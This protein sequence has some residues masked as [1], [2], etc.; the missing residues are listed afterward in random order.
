MALY[1]AGYLERARA[2]FF[3]QRR[4]ISAVSP[5]PLNTPN[6]TRAQ[7]IKVVRKTD[8]ARIVCTDSRPARAKIP[9]L[10]R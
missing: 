1:Q 8:H 5:I 9:T 2:S 6:H 10:E 7:P 3:H 4:G